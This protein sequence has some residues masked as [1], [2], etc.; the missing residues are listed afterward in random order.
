MHL[1]TALLFDSFRDTATT[2]ERR[3]LAREMHDGVAQEIA[4]IGY[5]VD[6]IA[7]G[8]VSATQEDQLRLL[9]DRVTRVVGEVRRSVQSLR[10]EVSESD[11]LG[12]AIGRLARHLSDSSG[13]PILVSADERTARLRPEVEAELMRIAQEAMTNAVRHSRASSIVVRC[14]VD[15]PT[16][17]IV[18]RDDGAGLGSRRADSHGLEI[19]HER[20]RLVGASL[21]VTDGPPHGTVVTVRVPGS[22]ADAGD[23]RDQQRVTV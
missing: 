11:S 21:A 5:L 17:E 22:A 6:G 9:R 18:V 16:A 13:I 3:R 12:A 2:D 20:A 14:S 4:S 15:A 1:D 7:A 19:M 8:A 10:S 23:R